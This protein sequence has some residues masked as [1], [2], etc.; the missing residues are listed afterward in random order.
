MAKVPMADMPNAVPESDLPS[1]ADTGF[2]PVQMMFN[3]PKSLYQNTIG[4]LIEAV[5][6]PLQTATSVMDVLAGGLYN[7]TPETVRALINKFETDPDA[8]KRAVSVANAVGGDYAKTYGTVAGFKKALQDDPFR[9]LG[10]MSLVASGGATATARLPAVSSTL[11]KT[12][13]LT[14]PMTTLMKATKMAAPA[15]GAVTA[16]VLGLTT[17]VGPETIQTAFES[18]RRG[19][20]AFKENI[21]GNVDK[22]EVL[23]QARQA[24][25]NMRAAKSANYQS[26]IATTQADTTKLN[27]A[28][29]DKAFNDIQATLYEGNRLKVGT[30]ELKKV[31]EVADVLEEW[32]T[33]PNSHTAIGLD[34][35]KQRLDAIYPDSPA[36]RQAQR[37]IQATRQ[38]VYQTIV[39]QSPEYAKTMS[40]YE[41]AI[42]LEKEIERALSLGKNS[43]ADT[44]LR[45][46]TSLARN[47]VNAN[48]GYRLDLA[49]ALE[50]QGNAD[51]LPAIAGQSMSATLPR[52]LAPQIAGAAAIPSAIQSFAAG[53]TPTTLLAAPLM[54]PRI[55]GEAVYG[56]GDIT[57]RMQQSALNRNVVSPAM[58]NLQMLSQQIPLNDAQRRLVALGL[59]KSGNINQTI[60]PELRFPLD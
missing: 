14:N 39:D 24:L 53:I 41:R 2:S 23:D 51:L 38:K 37:V 52:G 17:G 20:T 18:G 3:A 40:D 47:N 35:L 4:G 43:S 32:R 44:A 28:P 6:S 11:A 8:Q 19:A 60:P 9:V 42:N 49:K 33:D 48:Y 50:Q 59:A 57:R 25:Q 27:F 29:I 10:D 55:V 16:N 1:A 45:K 12:A 7:A 46:L 54:S 30:D 13:T 58:Q 5:S 31:N 15:A 56:A 21:R 34:A 22:T 36:Q 26:G